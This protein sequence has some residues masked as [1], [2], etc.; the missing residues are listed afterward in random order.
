MYVPPYDALL[1]S[2]QTTRSAIDTK[3]PITIPASLLKL[4][5]QL[6]VTC[7]DFDEDGYLSANPDVR[8]AVE[9]RDI[10]SGH[11]HYIGFGYFEGRPGGMAKVDEDWYLRAYPDVAE[12]LRDGR[13]ES[14][15]QHFQLI[16]G[17]EGRSPN[18]DQQANAAQWKICLAGG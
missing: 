12:A 14:A 1:R 6:A 5:L 13:V 9:R 10:E 7:S 8:E 3:S 18:A 11:L 2:L 15:W 16:G 17:G 4:L